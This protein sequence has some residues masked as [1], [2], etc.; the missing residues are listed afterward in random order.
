MLSVARLARQ[1]ATDAG[2]VFIVT[3][4][5]A[6]V[7]LLEEYDYEM[8]YEPGA[9]RVD[10]QSSGFEE[11]GFAEQDDDDGEIHRIAGTLI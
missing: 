5:G 1:P 2:A 6:E 9:E 3:G 7:R 4:A 10:E 11:Q 8:K